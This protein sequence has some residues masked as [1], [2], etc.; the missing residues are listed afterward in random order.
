MSSAPASSPS[1]TTC[2]VRGLRPNKVDSAE[3]E[4]IVSQFLQAVGAGDTQGLVA[5]LTGDAISHQDGGGKARAALRPIFGADKSVRFFFGVLKKAPPDQSV[6]LCWVN[7]SL[8]IAEFYGDT[9]L[10]SVTTFAYRDGRIS[11]MLT[12]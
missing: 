6:R 4:R 10:H 8:G 9:L 5:L 11:G 1:P 12:V 7:G 2:S 3:Q